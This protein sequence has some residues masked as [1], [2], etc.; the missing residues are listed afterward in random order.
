MRQ[1]LTE[2]TEYP[3]LK[4]DALKRLRTA[5][6]VARNTGMTSR[7]MIC[8]GGS[9]WVYFPWLGTR[10]FRTMRRFVA[11]NG[12]AFGL[13]DMEFEGCC[14]MTFKLERGSGDALLK[15]L[16][17]I[18]R[19]GIDPEDIVAVSEAPAFNKYDPYLPRELLRQAYIRDRLRCDEVE[20]RLARYR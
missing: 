10:S 13:H 6:A 18:S 1:V 15:H 12:A 8:I 7:D 4:P 14:Y 11:K 19:E 5:R 17:K 3:Y 16:A 9:T 2:D 20:A